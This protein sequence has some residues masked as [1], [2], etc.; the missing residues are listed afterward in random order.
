MKKALSIALLLM[1]VAAFAA[2]SAP[3]QVAIGPTSN[4]Q[5]PYCW[6]GVSTGPWETFEIHFDV[7]TGYM[8]G[9][10]YKCGSVGWIEGFGEPDPDGLG[11]NWYIG[12]GI[13]GG[14]DDGVWQGT[15]VL[16][17]ECWG[18]VSSPDQPVIGEFHGWP[19][20]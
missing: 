18:T 17:W 1:V 3:T 15:F 6:C 9:S 14:D 7:G 12:E 20:D 16:D 13:F 10:W 11:A 5:D 2:S 8:W 19:C 4:L